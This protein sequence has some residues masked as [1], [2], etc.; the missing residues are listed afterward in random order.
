LKVLIGIPAC[1]HLRYSK[2][3]STQSPHFDPKNAYNNQGYGIDIHISREN[4]R[5]QAI[6]DTWAKDVPAEMDLRFFYG[7]PDPFAYPVNGVDEVLLNVRDDYEYLPEKVVGICGWTVANGYDWML[8]ADDDTYIWPQRALEEIRWKQF[9]YAGYMAHSGG[10]VSGGP[11]YWL[12]SKAMRIIAESTPHTWAEDMNNGEEL[13]KHGIKAHQLN[14]THLCGMTDH[15]VSPD[16]DFSSA[17]TAHAM[18]PEH[19]RLIYQR[20]HENCT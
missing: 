6:R 3:E 19:M 12:S 14:A 9:D 1:K 15:W 10:Y 18:K 4:D 11:G 20:E 17:V 16:R 13:R 7:A 2:W 8:K 5:I